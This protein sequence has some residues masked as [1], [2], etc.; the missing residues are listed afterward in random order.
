MRFFLKNYF[1][2]LLG[3]LAL[4]LRVFWGFFPAHCE[5]Y[6]AR[7][8]FLWIRQGLDA[9]FSPLPFAAFY[10]FWANFFLWASYRV[11]AMFRARPFGGW[12]AFLGLQLGATANFIGLIVS[13]FLG[14]WGYNYARIP[15]EEQLKLAVRPLSQEEMR[16]EG[17]RILEAVA[18]A[19][20]EIGPLDSFAL[21][22]AILPKDLVPHLRSCLESELAKL[23]YPHQANFKLRALQPKG[24]GYGFNASG[25][26]WPFTGEAHIESAL[27]P[28]QQPFTIAHELAHGYGF[29]DEASC[30]FLAYLA[31]KASPNA[32][33]RYTGQLAYWRY[34]F[35]ELKYSD[36]GY[37]R[38]LRAQIDR[39]VHQDLAA[40]YAQMGPYF[41]F[42]PGLHG[43]AYETY[44]Q[45]QGVEE[46]LASYDRMIL[47]VYAWEKQN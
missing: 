6:Y 11:W 23:G 13:L 8:L 1:P 26:Y 34:I 39:G 15:L 47:L 10:L 24:L 9:L 22:S 19:R 21:D 40:I 16:A 35:S 38:Y 5:T 14:L 18:Q 41:E 31:C 45:M 2:F 3:L 36:Y 37:Y 32:F 27:H 43:I 29:G 17:S 42:V 30:N 7:G 44:L 46:G 12:R 4:L 20:A 28:L 25:F 33:I